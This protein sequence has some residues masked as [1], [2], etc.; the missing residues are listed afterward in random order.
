MTSLLKAFNNH[1]LEF[2]NDVISIFPQNL[3]IKTAKT[4]I[5]SMKT[6][7]PKKLI[8]Y[9]KEN[10]LDLYETEI[11]EGDHSFFI[12][13]EYD[14]GTEAQSLRILKDIRNLV[15]NTTPKNKDMTMK[16]IQNL[17]KICKLYFN[18]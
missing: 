13:K 4:M 6:V 1:L 2:M 17:T 7:N 11:I 3:D 16:Y 12:N 5:V 8:T 9:W 14:V 15:K 10:V 18:D